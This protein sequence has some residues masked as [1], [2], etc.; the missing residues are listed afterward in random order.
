MKFIKPL[1]IGKL[2]FSKKAIETICFGAFCFGILFGAFV[3]HSIKTESKFNVLLF[4]IF[5]FPI[6]ILLK[7][8]LK[9][10]ITTL[11]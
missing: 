3:A 7:P 10:E 8:I 11:E 5:Y 9:K 2:T 4:G 1:S 6:W